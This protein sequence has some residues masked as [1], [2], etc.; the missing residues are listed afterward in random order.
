M[1]SGTRICLDVETM[2]PTDHDEGRAIVDIVNS[3]ADLLP[4]LQT[5]VVDGILHHAHID[6]LMRRGLMVVNK[7]TQGRKGARSTVKIGDR[8]EKSHHIGTYEKTGKHGTCRHRLF[9]IGGAVYQTT[10]DD[11]GNEAHTLLKQRTIRRL[12]AKNEFNWYRSVDIGCP[13]CGGVEGH[14]VPLIAQDDDGFLRSEYVRQMAITDNAFARTYGFRPDSESGNNGI[15]QAWYLKRM[16][17]Y[18]HHNQSLR[19]ILHAAQINAEA[20]HIHTGRLAHHDLLPDPRTGTQV[21]A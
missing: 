18:G 3:L 4:G 12:G 6:P 13:R 16:P 7:P 2:T 21:A 15:E 19:M 1:Q 11:Q 17:A 8:H 10:A 20:W 5:V 9:G 14:S